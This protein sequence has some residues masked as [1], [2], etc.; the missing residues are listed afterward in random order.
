MCEESVALELLPDYLRL[1]NR[2]LPF[3]R[4]IMADANHVIWKTLYIVRSSPSQP[5]TPNKNTRHQTRHQHANPSSSESNTTSVSD[6]ALR[7]QRKWLGGVK[8]SSVTATS[9]SISQSLIALP[10]R[11]KK[12]AQASR[13]TRDE[14]RKWAFHSWVLSKQASAA[15]LPQPHPFPLFPFSSKTN[16]KR[17]VYTKRLRSSPPSP[18]QR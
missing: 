8:P 4:N 12:R 14:K 7:K 11:L 18:T 5:Q 9:R 2:V 16:Q 10:H 6:A 17:K 13:T 15:L 3:F 1:P